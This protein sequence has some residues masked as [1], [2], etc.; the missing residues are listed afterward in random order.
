[1]PFGKTTI[2]E[3]CTCCPVVNV[4]VGQFTLSEEGVVALGAVG[5][6][7]L[8]PVHADTAL[9]SRT[10]QPRLNIGVLRESTRLL[11]MMPQLNPSCLDRTNGTTEVACLLFQRPVANRA[12]P[13]DGDLW[14]LIERRWTART[15]QKKDGTTKLSEFVFHGNQD[16]EGSEGRGARNAGTGGGV[17]MR[18]RTKHGQSGQKPNAPSRLADFLCEFSGLG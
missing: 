9:K 18:K 7:V 8:L 5:C 4:V 16:E 15:I 6:V 10:K 12:L 14:N 1:V 11:V 13:L 17:A 3:H 2:A